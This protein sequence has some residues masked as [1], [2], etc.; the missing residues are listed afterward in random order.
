MLSITV[1]IILCHQTTRKFLAKTANII[2]LFTVLML[3]LRWMKNPPQSI[4]FLYGVWDAELYSHSVSVTGPVPV[5]KL[6]WV[7]FKPWQDHKSNWEVKHWYPFNDFITNPIKTQNV[8]FYS[9]EDYKEISWIVGKSQIKYMMYNQNLRQC[10]QSTSSFCE[11]SFLARLYS[12]N[13]NDSL[14]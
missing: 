9:R 8:S 12:L 2:L 4:G 13:N 3:A 11:Y 10:V 6:G 1:I 7:V 5:N 14:Q